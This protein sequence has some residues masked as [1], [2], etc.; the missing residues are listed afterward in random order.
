MSTLLKPRSVKV[1]DGPGGARGGS[2]YSMSGSSILDKSWGSH[3]S[4]GRLFP[5]RHMPRG[6]VLKTPRKIDGRGASG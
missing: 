3:R 5:Q 4:P 6:D 2:A 1:T